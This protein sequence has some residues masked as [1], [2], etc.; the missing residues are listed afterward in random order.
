MA[1]LPREACAE[2]LKTQGR[3]AEEAS[4]MPE[5]ETQ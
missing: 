1:R 5:K 4:D 2:V 3:L